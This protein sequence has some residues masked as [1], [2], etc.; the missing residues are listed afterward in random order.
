VHVYCLISAEFAMLAYTRSE[1]RAIIAQNLF[2][3]REIFHLKYRNVEF[4]VLSIWALKN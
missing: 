4:Q 2:P 1:K 3:I